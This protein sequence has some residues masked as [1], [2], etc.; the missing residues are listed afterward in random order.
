MQAKFS[1]RHCTIVY[2]VTY[3]YS[4]NTCFM[5]D[6]VLQTHQWYKE[7]D[8]LNFPTNEVTNPYST[9]DRHPEKEYNSFIDSTDLG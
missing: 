2:T 5:V 8:T 6:L 1:V 9:I 3:S 4:Y 7:I